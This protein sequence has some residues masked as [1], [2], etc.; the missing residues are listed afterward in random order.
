M[1]LPGGYKGNFSLIV[2]PFP[3]HC[4][5]AGDSLIPSI[6]SSSLWH[7]NPICKRWGVVEKAQPEAELWVCILLHLALHCGISPGPTS[8]WEGGCLTYGCEG[9]AVSLPFTSG[10]HLSLASV[11]ETSRTY[12]PITSRE[13]S[14]LKHIIE[15]SLHHC[16]SESIAFWALRN[17]TR[18]QGVTEK[19]I[20][21]TPIFLVIL[22]F[23]DP[24]KQSNFKYPVLFLCIS[25]ISVNGKHFH[26]CTCV[27]WNELGQ[28]LY[29]F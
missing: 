29:W 18:K 8:W 12:N 22:C 14:W 20:T 27:Y 2:A 4:C 16:Y 15:T 21:V 5:S 9:S 6:T 1:D 24:E 17:K 23:S 11:E 7:L 25:S 3:L 28:I 26:L 13:G 19:V 10:L